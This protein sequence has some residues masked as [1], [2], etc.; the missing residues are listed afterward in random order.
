M[1]QIVEHSPNQL[2][3]C[4]SQL[5]FS[6]LFRDFFL[7]GI[8]VGVLLWSGPARL[9]CQRV[10]QAR[11]TCVLSKPG[12]LGL[13]IWRNEPIHNLQGVTL[14]SHVDD[15]VFYEVLLQ[16]SEGEVPL[17]PYKTSGLDNTQES[18][19]AI[20]TFLKDP[21]VTRLSIA[22]VDWLQWFGLVPGMFFCL[23]GM[24]ALYVSLFSIRAKLIESYCIDQTQNQ[25]TY[26]YGSLWRRHQ[27]HYAFSDIHRI[28]LDVDTWAKARLFV[29]MRSGELL[30]LSGQVRPSEKSPWEG[31]EWQQVQPIADD[32]SRRI[33]R[34]WQLALGFGQ[35]WI[36]KYVAQNHY[37]KLLFK[38]LKA[39]LKSFPIWVF[40][41]SS[42]SAICQDG[43]TVETYMLRDI[44][45]V[46]VTLSKRLVPKEDGDGDQF[47][48]VNYQ[49]T[50]VLTS[51]KRLP[52]QQFYS[53][54]YNWEPDMGKQATAQT[55]AE[56]TAKR[57]RGYIRKEQL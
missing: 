13:G 24:Q 17:R 10:E 3:L 57:I 5:S 46:Q 18:V 6:R 56:E 40:D 36:E 22:Q 16:T 25:L 47:Y 8:G 28:V 19:D 9:N 49:I 30:C 12:W 29:E 55:Q 39:N 41:Q 21:R 23:G 2:L 35:T 42:H 27:E 33:H 45:D 31:A 51:G 43:Q 26:E 1:T 44:V 15:G 53:R 20:N 48:D 52:I 34:P 4:Q 54:E 14:T 38:W 7:L 50:L 37:A 11:V 32:V